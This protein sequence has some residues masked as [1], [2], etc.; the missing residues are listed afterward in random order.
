[1]REEKRG[2]ERKLPIYK[3]NSHARRQD[4]SGSLPHRKTRT[5]VLNTVL[6]SLYSIPPYHISPG[7]ERHTKSQ[8]NFL[9]DLEGRDG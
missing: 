4:G 3:L 7:R 1:M 5:S 2:R 9:G 8:K 6:S